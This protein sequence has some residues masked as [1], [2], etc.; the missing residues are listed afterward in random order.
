MKIFG[1]GRARRE[2][3]LEEELQAHL[4]IAIAERVARGESPDDAAASARREFGNYGRVKEDAR[5]A[6][7][8]AALDRFGQDL[9]F[10]L[11]MLRRSPGVSLL[12]ILCLSLAIGAN[13]AV[14]GWIEGILFRPFPAVAR[15]DRLLAMVSTRQGEQ[16]RDDLSWPDFLDF[17]R[18][19]RLA[20]AFI[21]DKIMGATLSLGERSE[22]AYGS[23]V[24]ANYFDALGV[25]PVLGRGFVPGEETGDKAH[26]VVVI[27]WREW[28]ERFRGDPAIVGKTQ[29]LNGVLHTIV[30]VGPKGFDGTFVG[31]AMRYFVPASMEDNFEAGGYKLEDRGARWIEGFVRPKPGVSI[32]QVQAEL[33]GVARRL[34]AAYPETNR[35][36]GI[37]VF[38]LALTPFNKASELRP[39]L[40]I[41]AVVSAFVLVV[42]CSNVG[43]LLLV[44]SL[45]RRR[46][47]TVRLAIGAGRGRLVAQL[48]TEGATLA[49]AGV[50]GGLLVA[51]LCRDFLAHFFSARVNLPE[52][53]DWRVLALSA[54]ICL[55]ATIAIGLIPAFQTR[56]FDAA[57]VLKE[58]AGS[59]AGGGR[60]WIRSGLVLLQLSI[61]FVLLVGA[62]LVVRS[63]RRMQSANPGFAADEVTE[64]SVDLLAAGYDPARA[65]NVQQEILDRIGADPSV[66]SAVFARSIPLGL[67]PPS[68]APVAVDGYVPRPDEQ[69]TVEYNEVGP[70]YLATLGI[71]LLSGREFRRS[72]DETGPLVAVVNAAMAEKYWRGGD[73]LGTRL[74]VKGRPMTVVGVA[75][76]STYFRIGEDPT[77][78]FYVPIRQN[79]QGQAVL[80]VRSSAP[81]AAI[82]RRIEGAIHAVDPSLERDETTWMRATLDRAASSQRIAVRL[83]EIFGG[84]ALLLAAVGLFGV[85]SYAVSRRTREMGVRA[86]LGAR[87]ADLFGLVVS[88]GL[89]LTVAGLVAGGAAA[90]VLTRL[91]ETLLYG[92]SPRDP[93][94]FAASSAVL[95][96]TALA[97]SLVPAWRAART[98]PWTALR[99]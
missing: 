91:I 98:D 4:R 85:V 5:E 16:R 54:A 7:G 13:T 83:L 33:S 92:V 87:R 65:K 48:L 79:F 57:A 10:G 14:F 74:V 41:L 23:I 52:N 35:G 97:A 1:R 17:R 61:S 99:E 78:F 80:N 21:A 72:D 24:S 84:L 60:S 51:R 71:P 53:L 56:S 55:T 81:L 59:V 15:Q 19:C 9:R 93:L 90:L 94:T 50:V 62:G 6:W 67:R 36:R 18:N 70:G 28:R 40:G 82:A 45:A 25:R 46:E 68:S 42:A 29:R 32:E 69:P 37:R 88:E 27:S 22:T 34:E 76:T 73:P 89:L 44:R 95:L 38:P 77:P 66:R 31:Y 3:E 49:G 30:G 75:K 63:L 20:D 96:A 11:R 58:E 86:A 39:V 12:A 43:N 64:T 26:P 8:G 2:R 47:M